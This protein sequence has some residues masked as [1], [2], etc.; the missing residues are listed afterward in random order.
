MVERQP[1]RPRENVFLGAALRF[2]KDDYH[3]FDPFYKVPMYNNHSHAMDEATIISEWNCEGI[4]PQLTT[5]DDIEG[6][7]LKLLAARAREMHST[8]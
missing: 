3:Y 1:D 4:G 5:Y 2:I 6:L 7:A 8:T